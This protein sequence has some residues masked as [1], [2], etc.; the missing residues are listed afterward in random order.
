MS[1]PAAPGGEP[2]PEQ[3]F[4]LRLAELI[5]RCPPAPEGEEVDPEYEAWTSD[6]EDLLIECSGDQGRRALD[7]YQLHGQN[8]GNEE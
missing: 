2:M 5:R 1:T 7:L 8:R 4:R 3:E 6:F